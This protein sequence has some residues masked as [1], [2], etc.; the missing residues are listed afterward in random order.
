MIKYIFRVPLL[1]EVAW[2]LH[3]VRRPEETVSA[4]AI[5]SDIALVRRMLRRCPG[6][7]SGHIKLGFLA[8]QAYE[9]FPRESLPRLLATGELC[10]QAIDAIALSKPIRERTSAQIQAATI[11]VSVLF[12]RKK[13]SECLTETERLLAE[14][15]GAIASKQRVRLFEQAG[16]AALSLGYREKAHLYFSSIPPHSRTAQGSA[17]LAYLDSPLSAE[18]APDTQ[19]KD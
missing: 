19:A 12:Y 10:A 2:Y 8:L 15:Q 5:R 11:R 16:A 4:E 1:T 6:W 7:L 17:A 18:D 3:Q 14:H 9:V 13:Y